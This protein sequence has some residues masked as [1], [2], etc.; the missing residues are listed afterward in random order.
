MAFYTTTIAPPQCGGTF[1]DSGGANANYS[2]NET[3]TPP[4]TITPPAGQQVT[5]T[6]TN[7]STEA[8]LDILRVYNGDTVSAATLIGTYSGNTNPGSITATNPGGY[9]TFS[10]TSN[11]FTTF[12]GWEANVTCAAPPSCQK[13]IA[14]LTSNPPSPP[15]P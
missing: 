10:F 3:G 5:V 14:L 4:V 8:G 7:F 6:F 12:P 9:L 13:P 2:N 11:G 15:T 1:Y